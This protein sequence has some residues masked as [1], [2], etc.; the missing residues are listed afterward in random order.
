MFSGFPY[1]RR[2]EKIIFTLMILKFGTAATTTMKKKSFEKNEE[3]NYEKLIKMFISITCDID[4][5]S[6]N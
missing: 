6:P 4:F 5:L 3:V 2:A 1:G